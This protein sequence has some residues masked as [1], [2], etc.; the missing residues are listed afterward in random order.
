MVIARQRSL[1]RAVRAVGRGCSSARACSGR[2]GRSWGFSRSYLPGARQPAH[3]S[4]A[5]MV[6]SIPAP[7]A[8]H[9]ADP[10][11][12]RR[13]RGCDLRAV[14]QTAGATAW[15]SD[16]AAPGLAAFLLPALGNGAWVILLTLHINGSR[17]TRGG[18][19]T[20]ACT[21]RPRNTRSW[22]ERVRAV[23]G[24]RTRARCGSDGCGSRTYDGAYRTSVFRVLPY[25]TT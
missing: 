22:N 23:S 15:A 13:F 7:R 20:G 4:S 3:P 24:G 16:W 19:A 11:R 25:G 17:R 18:S 2:W 1:A 12:A 21:S 10:S 14:C 6:V 8:R 9:D 5:P